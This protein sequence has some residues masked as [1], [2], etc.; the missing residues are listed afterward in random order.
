MWISDSGPVLAL[1]L[2]VSFFGSRLLSPIGQAIFS[3]LAVDLQ[4]FCTIRDKT[5]VM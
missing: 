5:F 2:L 4:G 1:P 3:R